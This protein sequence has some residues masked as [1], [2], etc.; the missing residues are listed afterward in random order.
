MACRGSY[1]VGAVSGTGSCGPIVGASNLSFSWTPASAAQSEDGF[2]TEALT[3]RLV[4]VV[5]GG[6]DGS[7]NGQ[8]KVQSKSPSLGLDEKW[9]D[10]AQ[11]TQT[12]SGTKW[13]CPSNPVFVGPQ[14]QAA[15]ASSCICNTHEKTEKEADAGPY[16]NVCI[17]P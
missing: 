10:I 9:N 11:I 8:Y 7:G 1:G 4:A 15:P 12:Q 6:C 13:S 17:P 14:F 5:G 16:C 3:T 2:Y